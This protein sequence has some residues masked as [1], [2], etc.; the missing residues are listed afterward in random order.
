MI[1]TA[2]TQRY[3]GGQRTEDRRSPHR[4]GQLSVVRHPSSVFRLQ[5]FTL[6]E[7]VVAI[8]LLAIVIFFTGSIFRVAISSYRVAGAQAEV[9]QK[10]RAITGQLNSDFKG[11]R[12]D[13]PMFIWF[14]LD[15]N[16]YNRRMDQIMFFADGDFQSI[17][18]YDTDIN[19]ASP[20]YQ[21]KIP[22]L[23]GTPIVSNVARIQYSQAK[24][25]SPVYG[26]T[27][28][29][30]E[31][32]DVNDLDQFHHLN[33]RTLAR[34]QH[35]LTADL[36][37]VIWPDSNPVN[38]VNSFIDVKN[39]AF[40]HDW[41]SLSQWQA[42]TTVPSNI[43]QILNVCFGYRPKINFANANGLHMLMTEGVSSFS[44]QWAYLPAPTANTYYWWPSIDPDGDG[45]ISDSDFLLM[46]QPTAFGV[47]FN[48][49]PGAGV[50]YWYSPDG[51]KYQSY[52]FSKDFFPSALK[53]TF[54]LYDSKGV[55]KDGQTFTHIV[56][57]GD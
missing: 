47:Y 20:S 51:A 41:L 42:L 5:G 54:T 16:D 28:E 8:A 2:N 56:Y 43:N 22:M 38:F 21:R 1:L 30:W 29:V 25:I 49:P 50:P 57:L 9:M 14:Q 40:E 52:T 4:G 19:P 6:I 27:Y 13:A 31:Q 18:T 23:T 36:D 46:A 11:L 39:D 12:K 35:L 48:M 34:R 53:F 32:N 17:Q 26:G 24:V 10:L 33:H 45:S 37:I 7:L 3:E 15:P 55:F 44:V